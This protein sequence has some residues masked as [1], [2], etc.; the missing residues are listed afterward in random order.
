MVKKVYIEA[1]EEEIYVFC[2]KNWNVKQTNGQGNEE[3]YK[4]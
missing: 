4:L 2:L 1:N 3:R